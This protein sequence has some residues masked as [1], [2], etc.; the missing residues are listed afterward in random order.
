[1]KCTLPSK[2][3]IISAGLLYLFLVTFFSGYTILKS[4]E[5]I[6]DIDGD[7]FYESIKRTWYFSRK[8]YVYVTDDDGTV[9]TLD[10]NA[11]HILVVIRKEDYR[12]NEFEWDEETQRWFPDQN[13]CL[14]YP[15]SQRTQKADVDGD[16]ITEIVREF[17]CGYKSLSIIII[18]DDDGSII[19]EEYK[20]MEP[21][22]IRLKVDRN[23]TNFMWDDELERWLPIQYM[24]SAYTH[25][26]D[27]QTRIE[28]V[29]GDGVTEIVREFH[30]Q[31]YAI[32]EVIIVDG[33]TRI[34]E[35]YDDEGTLIERRIWDEKTQKWL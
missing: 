27:R 33:T 7:G 3:N 9:Y 25:L 2:K 19:R 20:D 10:Y 21:P 31:Y 30:N 12:G 13:W 16:G 22:E 24:C 1:M 28:D 4:Q 29:D 6:E 34:S 23:G 5:Q 14:A 11:H 26:H 18:V 17:I 8:T 32:T 35:A 15:Y